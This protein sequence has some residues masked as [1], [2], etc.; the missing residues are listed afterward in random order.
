MM[1]TAHECD[2]C[3]DCDGGRKPSR[4]GTLAAVI[5]IIGVIAAL[6]GFA[7]SQ[8][9]DAEPGSTYTTDQSVT[10]Q[11]F[12]G[13][14]RNSGNGWHVIDDAGHEP[15]DLAIGTVT[16]TYVQVLYPTCD[17]IVSFV[18][19]PDDTFAMTYGATFGASVGLSNAYIK[20]RV[21]G[22]KFNPST[23]SNTSANIWITGRC[24][25]HE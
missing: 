14:I 19:A 16:S 1:S 6:I 22:A 21:N 3:P 4:W 23:W 25:V 10:Y 13:T 24:L 20:G 15:D 18:A 17:E 12:G 7:R 5:V 11:D 2:E 8:H 9:D